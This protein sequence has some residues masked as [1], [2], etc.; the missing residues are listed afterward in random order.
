MTELDIR[1]DLRESEF[2]AWR[3]RQLNETSD[4][5]VPIKKKVQ[6]AMAKNLEM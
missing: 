1:L 3:L 4:M 5:G 2:D 6:K